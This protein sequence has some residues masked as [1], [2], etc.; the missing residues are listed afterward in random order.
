VIATIAASLAS[1]ASLVDAAR[2]ANIAGSIVV[3]KVGTAPIRLQEL[4]DALQGDQGDA[5][6]ASG[7][8]R[9]KVDRAR[10]GDVMGWAEAAEQV[11]RWKARGLKVGF[12][13]GCFDILHFGHVTYLNDARDHCDRLI[14]GLNK[15][16]SIRILKGPERPVHNEESRAQ[17]IAALGSIDM[18]VLFGAEE[19]G[20]DNTAC[21]LLDALKPD[22]YFKGGDYTVDQI[23]EAPT[24][25]KN[26]GE[27]NVMPVY[28]GH[29]TTSSIARI[30]AGE[31]DAA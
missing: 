14:M 6:M 25:M 10:R 13:N 28:D 3:T 29:S 21:A 30:K 15:D 12:T 18:V 16:S 27:V 7:R 1:G 4:T 23:P 8:E 2:L 9:E 19:E 26:G 24:V 20:D 17:V 5:V 11:Q 22:V 31:K